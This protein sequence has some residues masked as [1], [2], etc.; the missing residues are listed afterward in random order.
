[1]INRGNW[2]LIQ[3]YL[4]YRKEVDQLL[5]NSLRLEES[6]LRHLLEW[7]QETGFEN[8]PKIRPTLPEYVLDA[9]LD[10][11]GES[12]SPVYVR[13]IIRSSY[14]FL[15]WLRTHKRGFSALDQAWLDTLKPPRMTIEHKEHEAVTIEE[16]RAIA[17]APVETLKEKRIRAAAVLWFLSGIRVGAFV[18]LP[19][20]GLDLENREIKQWPKLGVHTKNKKHATTYLLNI[21][22]LIEVVRAWDDFVRTNLSEDF[23]WF[24]N[25]SPETGELDQDILNIGED[26]HHGARKDL[27]E[28]LIKV[29]LPYHSPHK[30]RHGF[31]VY[32][33]KLAKDIGNLKAIS[34]NLMHKNISITD[35]IYGILSESDVKAQITS[36]GDGEISSENFNLQELL[37]LNRE[38]IKKIESKIL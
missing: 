37:Q 15:E 24:A 6:W 11:S 9:R 27:K 4:N 33:L 8:A 21:P 16:I 34:Q 10:G 35:G 32:A 12:L 18:T 13:K 7:A 29:D 22:E 14:N 5:D 2:L 19:I 3:E 31:A 25:I 26:R 38:V 17:K 30:F 20:K 36:L 1:M 28:W 23:P